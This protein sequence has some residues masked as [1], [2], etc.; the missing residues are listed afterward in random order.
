[1]RGGGVGGFEASLVSTLVQLELSG[2]PF[3][4]VPIRRKSREGEGEA[5][6]S[7]AKLKTT[8][9]GSMRTTASGVVDDLLLWRTVSNRNIRVLF[10]MGTVGCTRKVERWSLAICVH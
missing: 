7:N 10:A 9:R 6:V 8:Q 4:C 5:F 1:M 2:I 3:S